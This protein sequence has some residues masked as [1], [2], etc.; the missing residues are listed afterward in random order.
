MSILREFA[1][2]HITLFRNGRMEIATL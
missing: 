2:A 1:N